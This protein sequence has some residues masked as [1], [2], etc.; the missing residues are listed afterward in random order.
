MTARQHNDIGPRAGPSFHRYNQVLR[1]LEYTGSFTDYYFVPSLAIQSGGDGMRASLLATIDRLEQGL[2][3][4]GNLA[5]IDYAGARA[6]GDIA[7]ALL[8]VAGLPPKFFRRHPEAKQAVS[9]PTSLGDEPIRRLLP[10]MAF[11]AKAA[12]NCHLVWD[13]QQLYDTNLTSG[14][15]LGRYRP[16]LRCIDLTLLTSQALSFD[17]EFRKSHG[18]LFVTK[19]A[20]QAATRREILR[21]PSRYCELDDTKVLRRPAPW[22]RRFDL[23]LRDLPS[24]MKCESVPFASIAT[25]FV[26]KPGIAK[27][28][29]KKEKKEKKSITASRRRAVKRKGAHAERFS[30][31][32]LRK[33][34]PA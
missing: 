15:K 11:Y 34:I 17:D 10:H 3:L 12:H 1:G 20:N 22:A 16:P 7:D 26:P 8:E 4:E 2:E 13:F 23:Q 9:M 28:E 5:V 29:K 25:A 19:F 21:A 14:L 24:W 27:K 6:Q 30:E 31:P 33:D 32:P 18:H